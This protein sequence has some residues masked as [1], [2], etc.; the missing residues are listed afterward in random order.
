MEVTGDIH[1]LY[2]ELQ[3]LK[4]QGR[5][6][7]AM[8]RKDQAQECLNVAAEE[9]ETAKAMCLSQQ[10]KFL[11]ELLDAMLATAHNPEPPAFLLR[12]W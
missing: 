3:V 8:E 9:L 12:G 5:S 1:H 6:K 2:T 7:A 4:S 11:T 10:G